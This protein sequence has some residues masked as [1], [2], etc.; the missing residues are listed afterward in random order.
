VLWNLSVEW[1]FFAVV[2]VAMFAF[3]LGLALD[4]IM[5]G[6]GF[7]ATGNMLIITAGFFL[8]VFGVNS[9]GIRLNDATMAVG[10]GLAGAFV[11]L[12]VL[13]LVKGA[14]SRI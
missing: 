9:W 4:H 12:M 13:V 6:D 3:L 10:T 8:G 5:G 11:A 14:L 1:A 2:M 7:G